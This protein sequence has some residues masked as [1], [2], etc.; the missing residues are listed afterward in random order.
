[1]TWTSFLE[2]C[3]HCLSLVT[4]HIMI[5]EQSR[6]TWL[7]LEIVFFYYTFKPNRSPILVSWGKGKPKYSDK[8]K[9][10]TYGAL[11]L[12]RPF[13]LWVWIGGRTGLLLI[14]RP[15]RRVSRI[16]SVSE[17]TS[18]QSRVVFIS[19]NRSPQCV[20]LPLSIS[21]LTLIIVYHDGQIKQLWIPLVSQTKSLLRTTVSD[22]D[23]K[24]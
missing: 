5:R 21:S 17:M 1:M 9:D 23:G 15:L 7:P 20:C 2:R 10:K 11:S 14:S 19:H 18:I 22:L 8:Y 3:G 13:C 4:D 6:A 16:C 24:H 12:F